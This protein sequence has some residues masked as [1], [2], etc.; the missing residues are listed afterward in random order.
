MSSTI[1]SS[2]NLAPQAS[3]AL[4]GWQASCGPKEHGMKH[5]TV[6]AV[7]CLLLGVVSTVFPHVVEG[8]TPQDTQ[9]A[10]M[11]CTAFGALLIGLGLV[12]VLSD[13]FSKEQVIHLFGGG[14]LR[15]V[16]GKTFEYPWAEIDKVVIAEDFEHRNAA[17]KLRVLVCGAD[18]RKF[19]FT[20]HF[21]GNADAIINAIKGRVE[22]LEYI[23]FKPE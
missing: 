11:M 5:Y 3:P 19:R 9:S 18:R 10:I 7:I 14:L 12:I 1:S 8:N 2:S 23:K 13:A 17:M 20:S 16:G 6:V 15:Q 22:H 4:E 21:E